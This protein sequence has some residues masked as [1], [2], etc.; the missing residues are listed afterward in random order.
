MT[1]QA[2]FKDRVTDGRGRASGAGT[3]RCQ[4]GFIGRDV[5]VKL[6]EFLEGRTVVAWIMPISARRYQKNDGQVGQGISPM[7]KQVFPG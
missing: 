2:D 6:R 3:M 5:G 4:A 7:L 1:F